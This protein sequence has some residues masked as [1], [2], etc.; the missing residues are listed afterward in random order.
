MYLN[1]PQSLQVNTSFC[2]YVNHLALCPTE[3]NNLPIAEQ[4]LRFYASDFKPLPYQALCDTKYT[5]DLVEI[6]A[7]LFLLKLLESHPSGVGAILSQK[8]WF[9][10]T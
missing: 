1:T 7:S 4:S 2:R 5:R 6:T 3:W 9:H 8:I 10:L